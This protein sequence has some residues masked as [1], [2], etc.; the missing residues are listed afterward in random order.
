MADQCNVKACKNLIWQFKLQ[1]LFSFLNPFF[2]L[3]YV[4]MQGKNQIYIDV[5]IERQDSCSGND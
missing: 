4:N 3:W 1:I 5:C 2:L